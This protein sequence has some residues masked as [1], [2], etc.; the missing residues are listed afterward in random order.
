MQGNVLEGL[1]GQRSQRQKTERHQQAMELEGGLGCKPI[2]ACP[3][4]SDK[5]LTSPSLSFLI[6]EMGRSQGLFS[7]LLGRFCVKNWAQGRRP[8]NGGSQAPGPA[9]EELAAPACTVGREAVCLRPPTPNK[10]N[11]TQ[12]VDPAPD[13][14]EDLPGRGLRSDVGRSREAGVA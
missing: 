5:S 11:P 14:G 12:A 1:Q 6:S 4:T 3:V 9:G 2:S 10:H 7:G 8:G 13:P